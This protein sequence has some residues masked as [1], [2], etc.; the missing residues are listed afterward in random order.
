M[1]GK[2]KD[3]VA[4][5]LLRDLVAAVNAE[6]TLCSVA[7]G[8]ATASNS[9]RWY[10]EAKDACEFVED[11]GRTCNAPAVRVALDMPCCEEHASRRERF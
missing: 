3:T 8:I 2:P 1:N 7:A 6:G 9:A 11:S 4:E 5:R 10:L